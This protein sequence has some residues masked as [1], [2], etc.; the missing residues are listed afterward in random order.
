M[1]TISPAK[2][3]LF[4]KPEDTVKKTSS[5]IL[6]ADQAAEKPLIAEVINVG[7]NVTDYASKDKIVYKSYTT[8]DIKLDGAEYFL[9][10]V[11]DVLGKVVEI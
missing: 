8:N 6:L 9:I 7:N 2:N 3:Q 10:D 4:C 1:K 11:D 5:G